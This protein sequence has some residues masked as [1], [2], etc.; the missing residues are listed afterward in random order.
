MIKVTGLGLGLCA[1]ALVVEDLFLGPNL[2]EAVLMALS[3]ALVRPAA[4]PGPLRPVSD[5]VPLAHAMRAVDVFLLAVGSRT[6][7]NR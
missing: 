7:G 3:G 4:L 1:L 6:R 2:A 5:A